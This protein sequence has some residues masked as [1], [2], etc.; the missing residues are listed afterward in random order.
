MIK[1]EIRMHIRF[2][3]EINCCTNKLPYVPILADRAARVIIGEKPT[4]ELFVEAAHI[5]AEQ[6]IMPTGNIHATV[7]YLRHIAEVLT[8]KALNTAL[9]RINRD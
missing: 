9:T 8:V 4:N 6:E 5:A 2:S 3:W 1:L 7:G